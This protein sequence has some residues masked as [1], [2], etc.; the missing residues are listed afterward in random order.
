MRLPNTL[1]WGK[2][3][4]HQNHWLA[5]PCTQTS[6]S[7]WIILW[8]SSAMKLFCYTTNHN[9]KFLHS[10]N[11]VSENTTKKRE[12]YLETILKVELYIRKYIARKGTVLHFCTLHHLEKLWLLRHLK[13][14]I[15]LCYATLISWM[16]P[17]RKGWIIMEK[18]SPKLTPF[19]I[20]IFQLFLRTLM[21]A[22]L[23]ILSIYTASSTIT[24]GSSMPC[25]LSACPTAEILSK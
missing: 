13:L 12:L 18:L 9:V 21:I 5:G 4:H 17:L 11:L 2:L 10:W 15:L 24:R 20:R 14:L 1:T 16:L 23:S 22:V 3:W 25:L 6:E 19:L 8:P 7:F